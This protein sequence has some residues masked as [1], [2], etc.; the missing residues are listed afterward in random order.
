MCCC[1]RH[2]GMVGSCSGPRVTLTAPQLFGHARAQAGSVAHRPC[3]FWSLLFCNNCKCIS[4][5]H[6]VL[7]STQVP[8]MGSSKGKI[9]HSVLVMLLSVLV[10][11]NS[12]LVILNS[13][14]VMLIS[15]L[16]MLNS[17]LVMLN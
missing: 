4:F 5:G 6:P 15:V 16:V 14:L 1:S 10:M 11:L 9:T 8:F 3:A 7:L 17:V 12:V 2:L 13:V